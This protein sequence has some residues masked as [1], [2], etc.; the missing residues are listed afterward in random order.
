MKIKFKGRGV[1][2]SAETGNKLF[3]FEDGEYVVEPKEFSEKII[4]KLKNRFEWEEVKPKRTR[5]KKV[6]LDININKEEEENG[7]LEH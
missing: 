5:K 3:R 1:V 6:E 4:K 7:K 2:K